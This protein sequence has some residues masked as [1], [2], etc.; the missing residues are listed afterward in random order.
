MYWSLLEWNVA[1]K[2]AWGTRTLVQRSGLEAISLVRWFPLWWRISRRSYR[3][4]SG[5]W[6]ELEGVPG[7]VCTRF[8]PLFMNV[9]KNLAD[10]L[11]MQSAAPGCHLHTCG[12]ESLGIGMSSSFRVIRALFSDQLWTQITTDLGSS[13]GFN[14]RAPVF[15]RHFMLVLCLQMH[16]CKLFFT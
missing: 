12:S 9:T 8:F 4:A 11:G 13:P 16:I 3:R 7:C 14:W 2:E 15:R 5:R 6:H 10:L 1:V